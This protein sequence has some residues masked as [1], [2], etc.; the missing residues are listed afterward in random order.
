M[1]DAP[2]L[3]FWLTLG[4]GVYLT[5]ASLLAGRHT[6]GYHLCRDSLSQLGAAGSPLAMAVNL[7]LF[8]PVGLICLMLAA[9][10]DQPAVQLLA[11]SLA[12]G[13][14]GAAIWP[15]NSTGS[16]PHRLHLL[17]GA[18]EY[19]GGIAALGW[20]AY[21]LPSLLP[22]LLLLIAIMAAVAFTLPGCRPFTGLCQRLLETSLFLS[23]LYAA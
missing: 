11:A 12:C 17:C 9:W 18:V 15:M 23:L 16:L 4:C 10:L 22:D 13:Y 8:L 14:L 1:T 7:G 20:Q 3:P 19:S 2:G 21:A 5:S 6:P